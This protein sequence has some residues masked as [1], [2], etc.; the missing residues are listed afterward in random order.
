MKKIIMLILI[1]GFLSISVVSANNETFSDLQEDIDNA[2][3]NSVIELDN[4]HVFSNTDSEINIYKPITING[5]NHVLDGNN[6]S[7]IMNV[8]NAN[9]T[10]V[11]F[12]N[13]NA[14]NDL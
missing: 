2:N 1:I 12:K 10:N 11:I 7:R 4:D 3:A 8:M 9:I 14:E 13:G 6:Q 5:K